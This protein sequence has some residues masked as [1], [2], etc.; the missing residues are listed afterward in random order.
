M[1]R[2]QFVILSPEPSKNGGLAPIGSRAEIV[3]EL[4][5]LNTSPEKEGG[6]MLY[7]PGIRIELPP[8]EPVTQM[9]MTLTEEDIAWHVVM[10][11]VKTMKWKLLDPMSGRELKP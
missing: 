5:D 10:R 2:Q 4:R 7:G 1:P 6:E 9:L 8:G 3:A 11:L